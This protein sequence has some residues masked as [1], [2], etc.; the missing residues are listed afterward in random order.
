MKIWKRLKWYLTK[1]KMEQFKKHNP[2]LS[3]MM[4]HG[5]YYPEGIYNPDNNTLT[6]F[7]EKGWILELK[8]Y[9]DT[10]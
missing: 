6:V 9:K 10:D 4:I 2:E 3:Y 8:P 7:S 1:R 5:I